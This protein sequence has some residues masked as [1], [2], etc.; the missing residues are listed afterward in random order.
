M[1]ATHLGKFAYVEL[2]NESPAGRPTRLYV[3]KAVLTILRTPC[4]GV[5]GSV[6]P[7]GGRTCLVAHLGFYPYLG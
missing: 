1:G 4:E 6:L 2:A 7:A 5:G 3:P